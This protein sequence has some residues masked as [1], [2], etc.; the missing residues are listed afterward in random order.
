M[1]STSISIG[2]PILRFVLLLVAFPIAACSPT[3]D[4]NS[5][6]HRI[7]S[8][9]V[10]EAH[11]AAALPS[12][13]PPTATAPNAQ[14][15]PDT[16]VIPIQG[17]TVLAHFP[18]TQAEVD[19]DD[20]V[21]EALTDF[22][23]HLGNARDDLTRLGVAVAERYTPTVRY[24]IGDRVV[25]FAPPSDSGVAYVLLTPDRAPRIYYGVLTD[26]DLVELT[27]RF[28]GGRAEP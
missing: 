23:F 14:P 24:R 2:L 27:Q 18:V 20:D 7:D 5:A 1:P 19:A 16:A 3:G 22:Q 12:D 11:S 8:A 15:I 21:A 26:T 4:R 28:V 6:T 25:T 9:R 10:G 13:T 17:P